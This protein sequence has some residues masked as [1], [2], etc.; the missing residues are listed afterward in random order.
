MGINSS[1]EHATLMTDIG[2]LKAKK[3]DLEGSLQSYGSAWHLHN[4]LGCLGTPQCGELLR[5]MS[6]VKQSMG[7]V[8]EA[9]ELERASEVALMYDMGCVPACVQSLDLDTP[10]MI[11]QGTLSRASYE[12]LES[13]SSAVVK[14]RGSRDSD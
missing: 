7:D 14:R 3:K 2:D 4:N 5:K 12:I 11:K 1:K 9:L 13:A 6:I 8:D 10:R